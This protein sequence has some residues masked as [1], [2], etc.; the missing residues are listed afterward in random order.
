MGSDPPARGFRLGSYRK[1]DLNEAGLAGQLAGA[2]CVPCDIAK[3]EHTLLHNHGHGCVVVQ[4][5][6]G[7]GNGCCICPSRS[8]WR[9]RCV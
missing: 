3:W 6:R 5:A 9:G 2:N 4:V 8:S 1:A 7:R